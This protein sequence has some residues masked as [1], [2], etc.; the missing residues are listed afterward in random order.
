[1][2]KCI[3]DGFWQPLNLLTLASY[4]K[5]QG[6]SGDLRIF[7]QA[8]SDLEEIRNGLMEFQPD[9]IGFSPHMDSYGQSLALAEEFRRRGSAIVFGGAYATTLSEN[10]MRNRSFIDYIIS[11]EGERALFLLASGAPLQKI[12]NL[13]YR[14]GGFLH[15]NQIEFIE[16]ASLCG[17]DYSMVDMEAYFRN[18]RESLH[19]GG[20]RRPLTLLSQRG[21]VWRSKTQGCIYCSRINPNAVFNHHED[22]WRELARFREIYNIDS[23]IDVGDDFLGNQEWFEN[24]YKS[25]P[26]SMRDIG[27]RFIY[28]RVEHITERAADMLADLNVSEICLGL[29]SG[30]SE[31]LHKVKKGNNT[32]QHI[33]AVRRLAERDIKII[34]AFM[35]GHPDE[36]ELSVKR[37]VDHISRILSFKNT[38]ELVVSLFTPLPGSRAFKMLCENGGSSALKSRGSD[39]FR[40][41]DWQEE[42]MSRFC[43]ISYDRILEHAAFLEK[44]HKSTYIEFTP[45]LRG[46]NAGEA[47]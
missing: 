25:R 17:I 34:A 18:Y 47:Y 26:A 35:L 22:V 19:P 30:D 12:P 36:S 41:Q 24:F 27:I 1:M 46:V 7:D 33:Q 15:A 10:I 20:Y 23:F 5:H 29:E 8:L 42:W 40:V 14:N 38:N 28:S 31:I 44:L 9:L 32:D 45:N 21:C 11:Y 4:L 43:K 39:L 13:I 3:D 37:T 16:K 6:W 2:E